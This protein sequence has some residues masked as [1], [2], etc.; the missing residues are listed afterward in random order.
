MVWGIKKTDSFDVEG[1]G[2]SV[3]QSATAPK[4]IGNVIPAI[5]VIA[6]NVKHLLAFDTKDTAT[7]RLFD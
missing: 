2:F 4:Q 7:V 3:E 6:I 1:S 5:V